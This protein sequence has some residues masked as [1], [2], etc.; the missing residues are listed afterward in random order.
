MQYEKPQDTAKLILSIPATP[1]ALWK[2]FYPRIMVY[3]CSFRRLSREDREEL[4]SDTLYKVWQHRY[5]VGPEVDCRAWIYTIARH[6]AI[7]WLRKSGKTS[8]SIELESDTHE[9]LY[10][11]APEYGVLQQEETNFIQQFLKELSE[12]DREI[13]FLYYY[14]GL[15]ISETAQVLD[16]PIGTVKWKLHEIRKELKRRLNHEYGQS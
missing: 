4:A 14:E 16:L 6:T 10:N 1:E 11:P 12:T 15:I 9:D 2:E 13:A 7:D 5:K 8:K 3:L